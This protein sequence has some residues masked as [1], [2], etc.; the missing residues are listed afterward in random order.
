MS[1]SRPLNPTPKTE[2]WKGFGN[3]S[4]IEGGETKIGKGFWSSASF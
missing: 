4:V 3:Y 2:K 1:I